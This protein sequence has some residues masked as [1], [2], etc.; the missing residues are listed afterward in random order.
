[1]RCHLYNRTT[2]ILLILL[3][4][5]PN[6]IADC[7]KGLPGVPCSQR[8][9]EEDARLALDGGDYDEAIRLLTALIEAEPDNYARYTL[10]AAAYAARAKIAILDLAMNSLTASGSNAIDQLQDYLPNP[11]NVGATTYAAYLA[12]V[13][14]A[15]GTLKAIPEDL[16]SLTSSEAYA[17]SAQIQLGLYSAVYSVMYLNQFIATTADGSLDPTKLASMSEEDAITVIA[18]LA[19]AGQLQSAA[20]SSA[21]SASIDATL[22]AIDAQPGATRKE[23][24]QNYVQ[25]TQGGNAS[26]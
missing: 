12:D 9:S 18:T 11:D 22:A 26:G 15:V 10:L 17:K 25:A 23:K 14:Q 21:S 7:D 5:G 8:T 2:S 4:C 1:M 16:R 20:G 6:N 19:D 3:A 24:L 13:R